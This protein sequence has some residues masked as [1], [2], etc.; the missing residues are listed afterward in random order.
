MGLISIYDVVGKLMEQVKTNSTGI[1][2]TDVSDW[3]KGVYILDLSVDGISM[4]EC[5]FVK[6]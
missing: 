2:S 6:Q 3:S 4:G 5:K 1:S